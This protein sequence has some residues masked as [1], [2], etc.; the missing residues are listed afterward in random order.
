VQ[1]LCVVLLNASVS[2]PLP[3]FLNPLRRLICCTVLK[4]IVFFVFCVL[5]VVCST[6]WRILQEL[7]YLWL[8]YLICYSVGSSNVKL[9]LSGFEFM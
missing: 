6:E 8:L 3:V 5:G 1:N 9:F 4:L 2:G 7:I